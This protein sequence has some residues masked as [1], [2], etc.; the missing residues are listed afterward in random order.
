L[1]WEATQS[2][3]AKD[4]DWFVEKSGL[5]KIPANA[6]IFYWDD[7]VL[8]SNAEIRDVIDTVIAGMRNLVEATG[9]ASRL[10]ST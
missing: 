7:V 6:G 2:T 4:G 3:V 5:W 9:A 1:R 10:R 8:V